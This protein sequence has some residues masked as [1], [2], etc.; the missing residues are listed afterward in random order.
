MGRHLQPTPR[1]NTRVKELLAAGVNVCAASDNVHDPF[2]PFGSYNLLQIANLNAHVS[3]MSGTA[4][5]YEC[6]AMVTRHAAKCLGF[7][8]D[9]VVIGQTADL[10]VVDCKQVIDA[11]LAP[12]PRLATFKRRQLLV[13]TEWSRKWM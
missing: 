11:V 7:S 4:E 8:G 3:H 5:L 9:G 2:N 13:E 12:L 10:V 6:L 1:G